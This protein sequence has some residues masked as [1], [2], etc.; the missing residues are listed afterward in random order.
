[1]PSIS[2]TGS[3]TPADYDRTRAFVALSHAEIESFIES[4]CSQVA[5]AAKTA[6]FRNRTINRI[7]FSLYAMCYSGW[8]DLDGDLNELPKLSNKTDV[9]SRVTSCFDQYSHVIGNNHGIKDRYLKKLL[10]PLS[11]RLTD[12]SQSWVLEMSNFGGLR[13]QIAHMSGRAN[14]PPDPATVDNLI[15]AILLPGLKDLDQR[16][17]ALISAAGT[18][19][20]PMNWFQRFQRAVRL[21]WTGHH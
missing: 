4:R 20:A 13:G 15:C 2:L 17:S 5:S 12:L 7:I 11:I 18:V 8:A 19:T 6:W 10:E 14:Q 1:M 3:Y 21:I 9:D 16:L